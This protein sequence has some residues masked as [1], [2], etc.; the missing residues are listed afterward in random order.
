VAD[1]LATVRGSYRHFDLELGPPEEAALA[2]WAA[3][4]PQGKHG[5]HRY[6]LDEYGLSAEAVRERL[7][8]YLERFDVA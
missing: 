2:A 7:R 4:H 8:F 6:S 5:A 3:S 1:P